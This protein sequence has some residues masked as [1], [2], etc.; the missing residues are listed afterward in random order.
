[1]RQ[2][3]TLLS[4]MRARS[5]ATKKSPSPFLAL[6]RIAWLMASKEA[7]T[8]EI[9]YKRFRLRRKFTVPLAKASRRL[10]VVGNASLLLSIN[11]LTQA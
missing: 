8:G 4:T 2:E 3:R 10:Y 1:M 6:P 9:A 7:Y 11:L 5:V